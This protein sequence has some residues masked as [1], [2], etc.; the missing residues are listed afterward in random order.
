VNFLCSLT[1][2]YNSE[3]YSGKCLAF[4]DPQV[5]DKH[6]MVPGDMVEVENRFGRR[7]LVKVSEPIATDQGR[8]LVRL[9]RYVRQAIK[10]APGDKINMWTGVGKPVIDL[11]LLPSSARPLPLADVERYL[12]DALALDALPVSVGLFIPYILPGRL[13]RATF[14]VHSVE[15]GPGIV[16]PET[17]VRI[18]AGTRSEHQHEQEL[19]TEVSYEDVGALRKEIELIK[20]LVEVPI[21]FPEVYSHLTISSPRGVLFHG[22]PGVG[23]T[24]LAL[25]VANEVGVPLFHINGPEIVSTEFGET[26]KNLRKVFEEASHH[27]PSIILID[28]LDIIAPRR[29]ET[30]SFTT[31]RTVS[32]L[33]SLLDGLKASEGILVIGTTNRIDSVDPA[34]RRPGRFDKEIFIAPPN[35]SG[36]LE[37]LRIHA[38]NMPLSEEVF[39]YLEEIAQKTNGFVGADLMELCREAALSAFRR[40]FVQ[41]V[42][43]K[44]FDPLSQLN[45]LIVEK[46]DFESALTKIHASAMREVQVMMSDA[47]W[48]DVGGLR[49]AKQQLKELAQMLLL[50]PQT[51]TKMKME[52]PS[53]ILLHGPPGTGKS[54][55]TKAIAKECEANVIPVWPAQ[56]FSQWLGE[57]EAEIRYIFELAHRVAPAVIFLDQIDVLAPRRGRDLSTHAIDR[58]VSQLISEMDSI[59][60]RSRIMVIA[61]TNRIDLID[62]AMLQRFG[63]HIAVPL[64]NQ[65][66]RREIL[67]IYLGSNIVLN[68]QKGFAQALDMIVANTE[69][70]SGVELK[71]LCQLAKILALRSTSFEKATSIE[72]EHFQEAL[73]RVKATRKPVD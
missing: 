72:L 59:Q 48:N 13:G 69:G 67:Q 2:G 3:G 34:A 15:P 73:A 30:G 53:G 12:H 71:L 26:E 25:A 63:I 35:T 36:R 44:K 37:I 46:T 17:R 40:K 20:E 24:L 31:T 16:T 22:P 1:V 41:N 43:L 60:P 9:D 10:V 68:G 51:S 32:Q 21:R 6:G 7:A 29:D 28:E 55:L 61:A 57:S 38:R 42:D 64:P 65:A 62:P 70:F 56:I 27:R 18:I 33:L 47:S 8:G 14:V 52:F 23:K 5:M 39:G 49:E 50:D 66:E 45:E 19:R 54:L 4:I 11:F 58:V